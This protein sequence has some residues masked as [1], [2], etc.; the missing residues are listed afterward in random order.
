MKKN[1]P[2]NKLA[3]SPSLKGFSAVAALG[4]KFK[5]GG[6]PAVDRPQRESFEDFLRHDARVPLGDGTYAPYSFEGR[7]VLLEIVR[8]IDRV[9]GNRAQDARITIAGGAQFGKTILELNLAAYLT[10]QRFLRVGMFLP[11]NDLVEDVVDSKFRPDVLDQIPWYMEM[12]NIGKAINNSGKTVNRKGA[13]TVNDGTRRSYGMVLGLQKIPTTLTFD[14]AMEDEVDDI[15]EKNEKFVKGRLASSDLRLV[16]RIGTQ[17][18]NGRG[19]Q[20]A[21]KDGS[22]GVVMLGEVNPEEAFPGVIR[23]AV[24][25][26]P[27]LDDPKLTWSGDFRHDHDPATTVAGHKTDNV[28]YLAHPETGAPLERRTIRVVH[29]VPERRAD[30]NYSIRVPQLSIGAISLK[31][32]VGWFQLAVRDPE[33][34]VM[35]RCDVLALPQ[36]TAQ[37][38]TPA[39]VERAQK[40]EPFEMR[41]TAEQGRPVFGGID[42]GDRSYFYARERENAA[43]KRMIYAATFPVGDLVARGTSLFQQ[44]GLQCLFLDQRPDVGAARTVA[45]ILN[46]LAGLKTWPNNPAAMESFS[47]G[48]LRWDGRCWSG[49]RCA[50]VRF[51]KKKI[52]AGI[53][54]GLDI[55]DQDGVT[56]FVPVVLC[57]RYESIDRAVREFLTPQE[58]VVEILDGQ[59]RELPAMLLPTGGKVVDE[60]AAHI[61][62]GSERDKDRDELG[63]YVDKVANHFLLADAYSALAE[64]EGGAGNAASSPPETINIRGELRERGGRRGVVL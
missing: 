55:F 10:G 46:G 29:R 14:V 37:A 45:L 28:Y 52:G 36:S 57:N 19:Q 13:F 23:L 33:E 56:K 43:R 11:S 58:N 20:K 48:D 8:E 6:K 12:I 22:Q 62:T 31:Q 60:V 47:H 41:F 50:V 21:W 54:H 39:I 17:R 30:G 32:I 64:N 34:M 49:L 63:D 18:V 27:R 59:V 40:V 3:P 25:G 38:I 2:N 51:D 44:L 5:A 7:E 53:E 35:F 24:S 61:I 1:F 42:V 15:P 9:I 26:T 4:K 16:I